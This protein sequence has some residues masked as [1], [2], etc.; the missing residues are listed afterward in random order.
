MRMPFLRMLCVA[1]GA[2]LGAVAASAAIA[3]DK[4]PVPPASAISATSGVSLPAFQ[5]Q[6]LDTL[7]GMN[8][9]YRLAPNDMVEVEVFGVPDLKRSVR[10]NFAGAVNLPLVGMVLVQ[11]LTGEQ[12]EKKIAEAYAEKYLKDPQVSLFIKEF[13]TSRITVEGA[14]NKPGI[15]PVTS[16]L[17]LLRVM[18]LVGGGA[19]Y[20]DMSNILVYRRVPGQ[21][22][23][24][25]LKFDL[26]DI[27][28]GDAADPEV[29]ANDV[30]V[31]K[32]SAARTLLRDSLFRDIIDSINPFSSL[33]P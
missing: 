18:A 15:Y 11:G 32:R 12:A 33:A 26:N 22:S 2:G 19:S 6:P 17:T 1:V 28:S 27:R 10:V 25:P 4:S 29:M 24:E 21:A 13:T 23:S 5:P 30:I 3:Q 20:A 14:V 8:V 16:T 31:V 9:D 7:S